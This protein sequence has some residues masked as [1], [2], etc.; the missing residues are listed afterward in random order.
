[1]GAADFAVA[2]SLREARLAGLPSLAGDL[3]RQWA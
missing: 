3:L 2:G 1:M